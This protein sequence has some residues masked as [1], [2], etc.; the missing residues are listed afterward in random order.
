M[1]AINEYAV[2]YKVKAA[3]YHSKRMRR[4]LELGLVVGEAM[5]Q[6]E[7]EERAIAYGRHD[8]FFWEFESFLFQLYSA[9]D[10]VLQELSLRRGLGIRPDKIT[11]EK[12]AKKLPDDSV[13]KH[14][15]SVR[16]EDW[17]IRLQQC[18]H[19][20]THRR[21]PVFVYIANAGKVEAAAFGWSVMGVKGLGGPEV[22]EVLDRWWTSARDALVEALKL[23][24]RAGP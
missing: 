12:V 6:L 19:E 14:L 7:G 13:V 9:F 2:P 1:Q 18:R 3:D 17:F 16:N 11:W 15:R 24:R 5:E 20:I 8:R 23:M 22:F 21:P 10:L 4:L